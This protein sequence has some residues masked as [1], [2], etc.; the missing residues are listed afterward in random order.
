MRASPKT[1]DVLNFRIIKN[2]ES[3]NRIGRA[4]DCA[5]EIQDDFFYAKLQARTRRR[6]VRH[7]S[8][9]VFET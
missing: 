1:K 7:G 6:L 9:L 4:M 5:T 8:F 2:Q 3:K